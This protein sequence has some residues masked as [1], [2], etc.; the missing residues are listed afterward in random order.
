MRKELS[1]KVVIGVDVRG[2]DAERRFKGLAG[3]LDLADPF[4]SNAKIQMR[5]RVARGDLHGFAIVLA[6]A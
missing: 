4:Q 3:L 1:A 5:L 6:G 2:I